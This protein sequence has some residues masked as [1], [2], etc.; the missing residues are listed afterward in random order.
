MDD[1]FKLLEKFQYSTEAFIFKGKLESEGIEVFMQDNFTVDSNPLWS[2]AVGGIKLFVK[3]EDFDRATQ[4]LSEISKYSI[5]DNGKLL[6]CPNC[7]AEKVTL[8]TSVKD[9]KSLFSFVFSMVLGIFP[10]VK[11][12]YRCDECNF[13][14]TEK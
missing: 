14:F 12:R 5:G 1:S 3:T 9:N 4:I 8:I 13:E 10:F 7:E 2:N 6:V 11:Y